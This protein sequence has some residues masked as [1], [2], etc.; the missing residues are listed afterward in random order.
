MSLFRRR[1]ASTQMLVPSRFSRSGGSRGPGGALA[2]SVVWA[3][4][5][6]RADLI[7]MMPVDVFTKVA[8][9]SVAVN[10]PPL[11]VEPSQ[12]SDGQPMP[13]G[14]WIY[15]SQVSL[16]QHGNA[17]GIVKKVDAAGK[18]A[19]VDLVDT[20][21]VVARIKNGLIVEYRVAGEK[22]DSR[23]IW[24]E[25]QFTYPG[26]PIG[27]SPIAYSALTVAGAQAAAQFAVDW[28]ENGASPSAHL[29]NSEVK[30][31]SDQAQAI[32]ERFAASMSTG[33]VFV[34]GRDWEYKPLSAKAA[35]AQFLEQQNYT[36]LE[37]TRFFGVPADLVDVHVDSSTINYANI[38][39]RNVQLMVM[40]LGGAVKRREDALS[41]VAPGSRFVKLNRD[42]VLAMDPKTRAEVLKLKIESRSITPDE[43]RTLEDRPEL[44]EQQYVQFE[45]LFGVRTRNQSQIT[46]G[47]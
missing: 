23:F 34:T 41:R 29:R 39:E 21:D 9:L 8:G 26:L 4:Q 19:R 22:V 16:D 33:D 12:I 31:E 44:T 13:I 28:F 5:R 11:L 27:L 2:Q 14:E 43:I 1:E 18:P 36:D 40:N 37:L 20:M 17:F 42:A 15:S 10:P 46:G 7:S 47:S 6:L 32:K 3:A 35:E 45:R 38:T 25:R 30:V 24:H